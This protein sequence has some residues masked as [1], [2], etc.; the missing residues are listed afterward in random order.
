MEGVFKA[1]GE[2]L[3]NPVLIVFVLLVLGFFYITKNGWNKAI[4]KISFVKLFS[5]KKNETKT[6]E[7]LIN[8]DVFIELELVKS[9][10]SPKFYTHDEL[11]I[12]KGKIFKDFLDTKVDSTTQTMTYII[13][14]SDL[15]MDKMDLKQHVN[16]SFIQCNLN[17]EKMLREKLIDKGLTKDMVDNVITTFFDVRAKTMDRYSKRFDSIFGSN[18]YES[19]YHL[20]LAVNEVVAFE[21]DNIVKESIETFEIVNGVFMDL[22]YED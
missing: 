14:S 3:T 4:E 6:I 13:E 11:D 1:L 12:T 5:R 18:F 21:I 7:S 20:L 2:N 16:K 9:L 22:P 10:H 15:E 19:N 17:L 8:H